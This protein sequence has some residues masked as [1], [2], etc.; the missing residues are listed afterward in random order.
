MALLQSCI[1][2]AGFAEPGTDDGFMGAWVGPGV[3]VD[4]RREDEDYRL[5]AAFARD[6]R[7]RE[8]WEYSVCWVDGDANVLE[9]RGFKMTLQRYDG[10]T[11]TW[12]EADWVMNDMRYA[13]LW[14]EGPT[15]LWSDDGADPPLAL[16][17][18]D[19]VMGA[20][21]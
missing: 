7:T 9:C 10:L 6:D 17:R 12:E 16:W 5:G 21:R 1:S 8:L 18:L 13:R 3:V 14:L 2:A 4:I 11:Q 15:L 20:R 19:E